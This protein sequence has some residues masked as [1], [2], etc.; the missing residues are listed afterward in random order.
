MSKY[1]SVVCDGCG[2]IFD[3][4]VKIVNWNY[5]NGWKTYCS[6]GCLNRS[7]E[8]TVELKCG[9]CG[10]IVIKQQAQIKRSKSGEVFCSR[11]CATVYNNKVSK[12]GENNHNYKHGAKSYRD[13][14]FKL[15]EAKCEL[16]PYSNKDVLQVH[17]KDGNR[18]NNSI[19]NLEILCPT[20]HWERHVL[21]ANE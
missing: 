1:I 17:H 13:L 20:H 4:L 7:K 12:S 3:K 9:S 15:K 8:T 21:K 14:A 16:C 5:R 18:K 11:H 6:S 19:D 10:N 2:K